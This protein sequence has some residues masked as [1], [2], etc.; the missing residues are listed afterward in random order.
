MLHE[1]LSNP[2]WLEPQIEYLVWLQ[3]IRESIGTTFNSFFL[4]ITKFGEVP[5][6]T[7]VMSIIYW[8]IDFEAGL[9]LFTISSIG[10]F[11]A[12]IFKMAACI[13]RPWVLSEKIKPVEAALARSGGYSFPSG[14]TITAATTYGGIAYL[15]RK[16]KVICTLIIMFVLLIAFSRT[17]IGVHMPQDVLFGIFSGIILIF[18]IKLLLK[19]CE[20]DKNRYLYCIAVMNI[21]TIAGMFYVIT[22]SYPTDYINGKLLVNPNH[23][24]YLTVMYSGWIIGIINGAFLC[25]RYF[26]FNPKEYS[27]RFRII[28]GIIGTILLISMFRIAEKYLFD[29]IHDFKLSFISMFLIGIITTLVY[30]CIF[31][32]V[33]KK[34]KSKF[35]KMS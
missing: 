26:K 16:K 18:G 8:C 3:G 25:K 4:Y 15:L 17:Y 30:P 27:T 21:L 33:H 24:I 1:I 5:I 20:K 10:L 7:M 12:K 29:G 14:H 22:K 2:Q 31:E 6:S 34:L 9:Y 23:A 32:T 13:Y 28:I 35:C 11:F 19:W